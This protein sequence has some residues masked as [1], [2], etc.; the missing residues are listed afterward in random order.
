MLKAVGIS[1]YIVSLLIHRFW[2]A[3][4]VALWVALYHML[5]NIALALICLDGLK[6]RLSIRLICTN[7]LAYFSSAFVFYAFALVTNQKIYF[8]NCGEAGV[9]L[10]WL[11]S[12][13]TAITLLHAYATRK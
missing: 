3:N 5:Q 12:I 6:S 9:V 11:I 8:S 4:D 13:S 1:L 7:G 10:G 2:G